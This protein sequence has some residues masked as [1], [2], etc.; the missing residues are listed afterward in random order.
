MRD[1][2]SARPKT[3]LSRLRDIG[4][5]FWD[6][7]GLMPQEGNWDDE[8]HKPYVNEYDTY[9]LQAAAELRRGASDNEVISYLMDIEANYMGLG[10][11]KTARA[12][13]AKVVSAIFADDLLWTFPPGEMERQ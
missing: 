3:K 2:K 7:I 5:S 6:P 9:L 10:N 11:V 13:A 8:I 4:W 1:S 12:R